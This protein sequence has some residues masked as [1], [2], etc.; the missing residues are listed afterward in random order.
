MPLSLANA[1]TKEEKHKANKV[2]RRTGVNLRALDEFEGELGGYE[3]EQEEDENEEETDFSLGGT[4]NVIPFEV[5]SLGTPRE[6]KRTAKKHKLSKK[7][8]EM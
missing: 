1:E 6:E 8:V 7:D 5:R 4:K 3:S 2:S